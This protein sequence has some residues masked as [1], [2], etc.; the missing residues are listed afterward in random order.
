[1]SATP[2]TTRLCAHHH[3]VVAN[4][5]QR[6]HVGDAESERVAAALARQ[7]PKCE[8]TEP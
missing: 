1:M 4:L 2:D 5:A 8:R 3:E 6:D 7:C